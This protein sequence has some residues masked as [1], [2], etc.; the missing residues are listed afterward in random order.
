MRSKQFSFLGRASRAILSAV[1]AVLLTACMPT[2][3]DARRDAYLDCARNQ[4]LTVTGGTIR[5]SNG[6]DL[7]RLDACQAVPR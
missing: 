1:S 5:T 3:P 7:R 4:G 6:S 2:G